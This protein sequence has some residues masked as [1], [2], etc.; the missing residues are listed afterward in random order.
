MNTT[1]T[2]TKLG[3]SEKAATVY[4]AGLELGTASVQALAIKTKIKRTTIYTVL[5]ELKDL[6]LVKEGLKGK[7][8]RFV[9][10]HPNQLKVLE[11]ERETALA[12]TFSELEKLAA[13]SP[14]KPTVSYAESLAEIHGLYEAALKRAEEDTIGTGDAETAD[15]LGREWLQSYIKKRQKKGLISR[16][17]LADSPAI[18]GW[19]KT[20]ATD[21]RDIKVLADVDLPINIEVIGDTVLITS[22]TD[23]TMALSIESTKVAQG[24]RELLELTWKATED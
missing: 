20:S 17:L 15:R 19:L 11:N 14:G 7:K 22:L 8:R 13:R 2:L 18:A 16:V 1:T 9:F 10:A 12:N 5:D 3:L 24:V 4:L 6:Q 23:E 21:K